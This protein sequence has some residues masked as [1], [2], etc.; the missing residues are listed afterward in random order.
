MHSEGSPLS[1]P[2]DVREPQPQHR[3]RGGARPGAGRKPK[4]GEKTVVIRVP[5]SLRAEV[6]EFVRLRCEG[7]AL[8]REDEASSRCAARSQV[9]PAMPRKRNQKPRAAKV[10]PPEQESLFDLS[11]FM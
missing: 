11:L 4:W 5:E 7:V 6:E 10:P 2:E 1:K 9:E 8:I 3:G